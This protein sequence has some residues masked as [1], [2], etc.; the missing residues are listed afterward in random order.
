MLGLAGAFGIGSTT[1]WLM[2]TLSDDQR[3]EPEADEVE[4]EPRDDDVVEDPRGGLAQILWS[5][6]TDQPLAAITFDDGP[7]PE[8]TPRILDILDRYGVTATF[9]AMGHNAQEHPGLLAQVREAGHEIGHH[10]WRHRNFAVATVEETRREID[11]GARAV[12]D[13]AETQLRWFRPPKGRLTEAALRLVAKHGHDIVLWSVTR[14]ALAERSPRR[15]A[16][17]MV[18]QV[19]RGDII[20]LHDGIGRGTFDGGS[21]AQELTERRE[22]EVEALPEI[23]ERT[24][25]TGIRLGTVSELEATRLPS[26]PRA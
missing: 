9:M 18:N 22:T 8:F 7:D 17:Y 13:T 24:L 1:P 11:V 21:L 25:A 6:E 26:R 12:E 2:N 20:L 14:G 10:S 16:E 3:S 15:V 23:L 19:G 5:V 4:K